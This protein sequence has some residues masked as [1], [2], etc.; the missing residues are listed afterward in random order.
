M[1]ACQK[2][3]SL[4]SEQVKDNLSA[5]HVCGDDMDLIGGKPTGSVRISFGYMSNFTD[6][7]SFLTFI[8]ECFLEST[9]NS[10]SQ[11]GTSNTHKSVHADAELCT[12]SIL[13]KHSQDT[14]STVCLN[15]STY[16]STERDST[17]LSTK[18]Q[19][20]TLGVSVGAM[21]LDHCAVYKPGPQQFV[22]SPHQS[23]DLKL[24]KICLYPIK[25]CA[26]FEVMV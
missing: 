1:G 13:V 4:S 11:H 26:A 2:F 7:K 9:L 18:R 14:T 12:N 22:D 21:T 19:E 23:K 20:D 25:S 17:V 8:E 10:T 15:N 24:E 16:N 5:G 3:L 6:A